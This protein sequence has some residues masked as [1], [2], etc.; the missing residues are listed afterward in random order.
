MA[1]NPAQTVWAADY[2]TGGMTFE[3]NTDFISHCA[4]AWWGGRHAQR[5]N[6]LFLDGHVR[7]VHLLVGR[8]L[9]TG[10]SLGSWL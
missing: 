4:Y 6:T 3:S 5:N 8:S 9:W 10:Y 1:A 2:A 7:A